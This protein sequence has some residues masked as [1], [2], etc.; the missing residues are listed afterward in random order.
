MS[1]LDDAGL[2]AATLAGDGEAY[3][4]VVRRY[5]EAV[6]GIAL[7]RLRNF[8]EAEDIAQQVFLEA[9]ERLDALADPSR[10]AAWLRSITVHQCIDL[11][12]RRRD[13]VDLDT[14][15]AEVSH[16]P[17]PDV[18]L[19]RHELRQQVMDAIG[20][21]SKTQRE[22]TT[23]FYMGRYSLKQIAA[24]QEVPLGTV[25]RRLH[26]ARERLK[27]EML[28]V[29]EDTLK[30]EAPT[31]EF[32]QRVFDLL[33]LHGRPAPP[34]PWHG[35]EDA[36]RIKHELR[37]IGVAGIEGF[38]R[39]MQL[40]HAP[41]RRFSLR[42]LSFMHEAADQSA[43]AAREVLVDL[44]KEALGDRSKKVRAWAVPAL[45]RLDVDDDRKRRE[46]I[47]LILPLLRDPT[48]Y[49]RDRVSY[50]LY[51]WA[52]DIPLETAARALVVLDKPE[53]NMQYLLE[54]VLDARKEK[55]NLSED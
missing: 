17:L 4:T 3:N 30:A 2:V 40:P 45:L 22:T 26:D 41:T 20:K 55:A 18:A 47:P 43:G 21:L 24:M 10:L 7:A 27:T 35:I 29:V 5:Q 31:E 39:A 37:E 9:Y 12:R 15:E 54:L 53:G 38:A 16:G 33:S 28:H 23:L 14:V 50:E 11:L 48:A 8:H 46:F 34:G 25:K 13:N 1:T 32:S 42:Y 51:D 36:L 19:E 49:V 52:A 44:M 6:F